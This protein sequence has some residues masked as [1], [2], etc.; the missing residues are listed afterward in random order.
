MPDRRPS[1]TFAIPSGKEGA[2]QK[3]LRLLLM[4]RV[5][6]RLVHRHRVRVEVRGDSGHVYNVTYTNSEWFCT[7]PGIRPGC[8]HM[9]ATWLVI[10]SELP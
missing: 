1:V 3:A 6:V 7:C 8:S 2:R 4:G 5:R 10:A 9:L